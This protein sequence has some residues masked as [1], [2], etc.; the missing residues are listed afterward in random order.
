MLS[1]GPKDKTVVD[2]WRMIW[3]KNVQVIVMVTK[4]VEVGK[5]KCAQYWPEVGGS[6]GGGGGKGGRGDKGGGRGEPQKH[7]DFTVAISDLKN[8]DG[9]D[10]TTLQVEHKVCCCCCSPQYNM[11]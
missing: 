5:R 2:F 11:L 10:M 1:A 9:Y 6:G 3:E 4:C 8:C 7:G